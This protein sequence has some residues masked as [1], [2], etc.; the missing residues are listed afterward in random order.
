MSGHAA[1]TDACGCSA[2]CVCPPPPQYFSPPAVSASPTR[3]PEG[4]CRGLGCCRVFLAEAHGRRQRGAVP[5]TENSSS[6]SHTDTFQH[7]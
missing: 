5:G 4:L 3:W 7:P 2:R 6:C 1:A